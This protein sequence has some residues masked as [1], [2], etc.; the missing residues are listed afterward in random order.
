MRPSTEARAPHELGCGCVVVVEPD[1]RRLFARVCPRLKRKLEL[2]SV[3][4][5]NGPP[6]EVVDLS[7]QPAVAALLNGHFAAW[8]MLPS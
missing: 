8:V 6:G 4:L 1:G 5:D 2:L 7:S 3:E